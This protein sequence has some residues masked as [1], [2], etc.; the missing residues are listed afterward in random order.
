MWNTEKSITLSKWVVVIFIAALL[1]IVIGGPW[2]MPI[3][4]RW[5][6]EQLV[7]VFLWVIYTTAV[8]AL[9]IL[10]CLYRILSRLT[11]GLIF[12]REN[13]SSL[14]VISWLCFVCAFICLV[15]GFFYLPWWIVAVAAAFIGL[16]VRV[17]RNV[18]A[19]AVALQDEI[20]Y[21]I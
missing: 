19:R 15:A 14:R 17:V 9:F 5:G 12:V 18:F 11:K 21:T 1:T 3:I 6:R 2:L 8:P 7:P 16:I 13:V 10:I 4:L 20:D